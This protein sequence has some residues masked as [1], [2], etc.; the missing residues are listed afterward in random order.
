MLL[1]LS[2]R[3]LVCEQDEDL[4]FETVSLSDLDFEMKLLDLKNLNL[5]IFDKLV[6]V[7]C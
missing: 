6:H 1:C 5:S 3:I 4:D 7:A 2:C